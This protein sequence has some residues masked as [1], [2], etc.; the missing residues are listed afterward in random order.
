MI[1]EKQTKSKTEFSEATYRYDTTIFKEITETFCIETSF[2]RN[3]KIFHLGKIKENS[4]FQIICLKFI[5]SDDDRSDVILLK[6]LSYLWDDVEILVDKE[7]NIIKVLNLF[8]LRLYWITIKEKLSLEYQGSAVERHFRTV[9]DL[10]Q[11][12][13]EVCRFLNS[14]KMFGMLFNGQYGGYNEFGIKTR[15]ME[16]NNIVFL[17]NLKIVKKGNHQEV[18]T[19]FE[20]NQNKDFESYE[21]IFQYENNHLVEAFLNFKTK[22]QRTK[23]SLLWIG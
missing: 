23:Y 5:F 9:D 8:K 14:Y 12:E 11:N 16:E 6:K 22:D 17:E 19:S 13:V 18:K 1:T 21:G 15:R 3:L 10:L 2:V 7:N 20:E 4:Y